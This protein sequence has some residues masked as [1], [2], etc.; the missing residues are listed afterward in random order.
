MDGETP[1]KI[2]VATKKT[3]KNMGNMG[4]G[5]SMPRSAKVSLAAFSELQHHVAEF[6]SASSRSDKYTKQKINISSKV[7][8]LNPNLFQRGAVVA[9][10]T[11]RRTRCGMGRTSNK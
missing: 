11:A 3:E 4:M 8:I 6:F 10:T 2:K 1:A 5:K 9:R 7:Q